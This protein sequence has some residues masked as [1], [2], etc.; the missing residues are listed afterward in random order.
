MTKLR[1]SCNFHKLTCLY[2][3]VAERKT[4]K[5]FNNNNL[6]H[7]KHNNILVKYNHQLYDILNTHII[8]HVSN[9]I[10]IKE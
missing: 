3:G 1:V 8:C 10:N 9:N 4:K 5:K 6:V 7:N 2:F